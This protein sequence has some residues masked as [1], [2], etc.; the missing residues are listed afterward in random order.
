[1]SG[2]GREKQDPLVSVVKVS[3][4]V[5]RGGNHHEEGIKQ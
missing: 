5:G 1:M 3:W 4:V 2:G